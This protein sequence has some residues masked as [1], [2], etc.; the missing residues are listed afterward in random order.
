[1]E[2][3]FIETDYFPLGIVND[4]S[5]SEKQGG[6]RPPYWEMVFWWT[7]KPLVGARAVIA[8]S[9]LPENVSPD[10]FKQIVRLDAKTPHR[11]NPIIPES[12]KEYFEG[13]KLLDPFAGFGSIPLEAVRLGLDATAVELLPTAY[14][15]LKAVLEY[16]AKYGK[17]EVTVVEEREVRGR[18]VRKTK[19]VKKLVYDVQKWGNWVTE[20]LKEDEDI[21]ELYDED[22]A[23]YIGTWEVKCPH[24]ERW[25]PIVGNWWLA[26]VKDSSGKYKRLAFMR[27]VVNGDKVD[28]EV[29]DVNA[30][31]GDVSKA[32]VDDNVVRIGEIAFDVPEANIEAKRS[33]A[34]CLL[35]GNEIKF[36]DRE[37][38]HYSDPKDVP[39]R[40][41]CKLPRD[42]GERLAKDMGNNKEMEIPDYLKEALLESEIDLTENTVLEKKKKGKEWI[43]TTEKGIFVL[44]LK[45]AGLEVYLTDN[46]EWFVK[47]ALKKYH[48]GDER[49]ARQ[50][51]LVKVK[52]ADGDLVFEPC[53][54]EDNAKLERAKERVKELIEGGDPDVPLDDI[55]LY[56]PRNVWVVNYGF[57]KWAHM[58]NPRQLLTLVKLVKLIREAG[59]K[60]EEEKI[61]E[62]WSEEEAKGYAEAVV[63][64]LAIWITNFVRYNSIVTCW[65]ATYW[66]QLKVKQSLSMRGIAMMWNWCEFDYSLGLESFEQYSIRS[67][68]YVT[69][70]LHNSQ[71]LSSFIETE[72]SN[73]KA[74]VSLDDATTLS[75]LN[76][77]KYDIIV[78]DP[79]YADDVPYTELSDFYYV[80]LKRALSDSDGKKLIPRFHPEAFFRETDSGYEEIPT[81]WQEFARREIS[82]NPGRF[83]DMPNRNEFASKHFETL[84]N[85]AFLSMKSR[86][87]E[88]G[89]LVTYYAH[90]SNEAWANLLYAGWKGAKM[91]VTNAF[92]I[93]TESAQRVTGRGKMRLDT[94][95]VVVWRDGV[96][97]TARIND[98]S[99]RLRVIE[100]A[101]NKAL[102]L[103][104]LSKHRDYALRGRDI[105]IGTMGAVLAELTKYEDIR[106][107]KGSIDT[108]VLTDK[109][110][111]PMTVEAM[112]QALAEFYGEGMEFVSIEDPIARYYLL[113]KAFFG[114]TANGS[115]FER[116]KVSTNELIMLKLATGVDA[117]T[118][119]RPAR[120]SPTA[121]YLFKKASSGSELT[122]LEP[123]KADSKYLASY[124]EERG[125]VQNEV[126]ITNSIDMF[127]YLAYLAS[128]G[129]SP[130]D[131]EEVRTH[132][133]RAFDEAKSIALIL[134]KVLPYTDPEKRLADTVLGSVFGGV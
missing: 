85:L 107:A 101:K 132:N 73:G 40:L 37:G 117:S 29:V 59:K 78:T 84:F 134:S 77:E 57:F 106:D 64:Y 69:S 45:R 34:R 68:S 60:V 72:Q 104:K 125:I 47:W 86:L 56:D 130:R 15:F 18:K 54:D 53:T 90:T 81:Q 17:E 6:G 83:L 92:P 114:A 97:G 110:V 61:Q 7:R 100:S 93:V 19:K 3:R 23:V 1:M 80:W 118:L 120:P 91:H 44:M 82:T 99:F 123:S 28:I 58:F 116:L 96:S 51:L 36:I 12:V 128:K 5:V 48:E 103:L 46:V 63:T 32:E 33:F 67:L 16:P 66:G 124:L 129:A 21:K 4:K 98:Q 14:V 131:Y 43:I 24:C 112:F 30:V 79:P 31:V 8:A 89:I 52:V 75:K 71:T 38:N 108:K 27:P 121:T 49:F 50:R 39:K 25:T 113:L 74:K 55:P 35:C 102:S 2:K 13:K 126:I 94:S 105:L 127:H 109:Y 87:K 62:G 122:F 26:R 88:D 111:F 76:D 11:E 20:R 119:V 9:L 42:L 41:K 95:I 22:V 133:P 65:D 10:A 70:K 115:K